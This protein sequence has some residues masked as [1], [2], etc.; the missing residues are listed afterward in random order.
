MT[1]ELHFFVGTYSRPLGDMAAHGEGI[2]RVD[3]DDATG[4]IGAPTLA[5]EC[6]SPSYIALHPNGRVL[7]AVNEVFA[8]ADPAVESF[9]LDGEGALTPQSRQPIPGELP[10]HLA[11]DPTGRWLA[12]AQYWS[13]DFALF[14]IS[15]DGSI[16][17]IAAHFSPTGSGPNPR[18]QEGPHG[19]Y[20]YFND[21]SDRL[22]G[23]DLGIDRVLSYRVPP[24]GSQPVTAPIAEC[25]IPAGAGPRHMAVTRDGA[26]AVVVNELDE[27]VAILSRDGAGWGL[28]G[29]IEA[30]ACPAGTDGSLAAIRFSPD[31]RNVYATGRRQSRVAVFS[32][33]REGPGLTRTGDADAGGIAPRDFVVSSDGRWALTANQ[34]N[35]QVAS[36]ARDPKSGALIPTG[37]VVE[38]GSACAL[39][40][41]QRQ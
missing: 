14:P 37:S 22:D 16:D 38:I 11:T 2:Y 28:V 18:R 9:S 15:A 3:V 40:Q 34:D 4:A 23:V 32:V 10:C 12:T 1:G 8:D 41:W 24:P 35:S 27:T 33:D 30:F 31:E 26:M 6:A 29:T 20:V 36:F 39:L 13:G 25:V 7:Y 19:H 17:P 5:A 21:A